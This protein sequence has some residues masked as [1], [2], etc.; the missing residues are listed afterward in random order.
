MT[1]KLILSLA[2][3]IFLAAAG[4]AQAPTAELTGVVRDASGAVV[5]GAQVAAT[6][7]DTGFTRQVGSNELGYFTVPLLPPGPYRMSVKKEGFR[8]V[9]RKGLRLHVNDKVTVDYVLDVG[10]L[11]ETMTVAAETPLLQTEQAS[12][13]AVIDN[14]KIVNLP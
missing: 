9:E 4:F 8:A 6:N 11:A 5:P 3:L 2:L 10:A 7:E 12:Q 14:A 13:G 1:A